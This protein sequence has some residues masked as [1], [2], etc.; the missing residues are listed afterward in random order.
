MHAPAR[1]RFAQCAR[2]VAL[3]ALPAFTAP[4]AT[5]VFLGD[6]VTFKPHPLAR[7][8]EARLPERTPRP[9]G[10]LAQGSE[11]SDADQERRNRNHWPSEKKGKWQKLRTMK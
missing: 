4:A 3:F 1:P 9:P 10:R 8:G 6:G 2:F 5:A 11:R 7:Q